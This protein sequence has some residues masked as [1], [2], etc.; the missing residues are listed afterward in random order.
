[1]L[2][3]FVA[4]SFSFAQFVV[5]ANGL[6]KTEN[7][8]NDYYVIEVPNCTQSDLYTKTLQFITQ[9]YN[10]PKD[11]ISSQVENETIAVTARQTIFMD[12]VV[13][14]KLIFRFKDGRVRF[15][16]PQIISMKRFYEGRE[17]HLTF[18]KTESLTSSIWIFNK[19]G[20]L[21]GML[22]PTYKYDIEDIFNPIFNKYKTSL[23]DNS[24]QKEEDN[25]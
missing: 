11:V 1:M 5:T 24:E 8:G 14:Y 22:I 10:S 15:D 6:E 17:Q 13:N 20:E 18:T 23:T 25:W 19:K 2:L 3:V 7:D 9:I 4:T 21:R 12:F 16:T